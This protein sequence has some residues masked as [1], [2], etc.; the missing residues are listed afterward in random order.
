MSSVAFCHVILPASPNNNHFCGPL[1]CSWHALVIFGV[2][3][4]TIG[5]FIFGLTTTN[6][7]YQDIVS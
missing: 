4:V 7:I 3:M 2:A 6:S 1:F 5:A